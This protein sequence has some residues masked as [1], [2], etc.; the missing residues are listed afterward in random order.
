[1]DKEEI[2]TKEEL[3]KIKKREINKRFREI[4]I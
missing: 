4:K 2:L 3:K 1:M